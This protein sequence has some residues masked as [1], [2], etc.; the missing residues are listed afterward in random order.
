VSPTG[1][2]V[3]RDRIVIDAIAGSSRLSDWRLNVTY[4]DVQNLYEQFIILWRI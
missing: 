2:T 4:A 3:S 1:V